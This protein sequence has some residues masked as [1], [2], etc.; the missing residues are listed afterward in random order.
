MFMNLISSQAC[1][2]LNLMLG[3]YVNYILSYVFAMSM[4]S[5]ILT[6]VRIVKGIY[7]LYVKKDIQNIQRT[8][9]QNN[10]QQHTLD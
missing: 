7:V 1:V 9:K 10:T 2:Q 8:T 3:F 5:H 4:M 6:I